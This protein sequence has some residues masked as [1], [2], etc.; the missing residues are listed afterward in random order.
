VGKLDCTSLE[1]RTVV[2]DPGVGSAAPTGF[3]ILDAEFCF[4]IDCFQRLADGCLQRQEVILY[5]LD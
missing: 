4:T 1:M 2:D 5:C 3:D